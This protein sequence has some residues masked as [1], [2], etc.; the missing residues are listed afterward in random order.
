MEIDGAFERLRAEAD[1]NLAADAVDPARRRFELSLEVRYPG[2]DSTLR[3]EAEAGEGLE[4]V[5]GRFHA[6]HEH[7]FGHSSRDSDV[8]F[9]AAR[10]VGT[11]LGQT[12][13]M[14]AEM[15]ADPGEPIESRPILFD[16]AAGRIETPIYVRETLA[17]GQRIAGPAIVEQMDTTTIVPPEFDS[18]V[19]P[20]GSMIRYRK[21]GGGMSNDR[22]T[23]AVI[24]S[25][26]RATALEMSEALR[27]SAH[28]PIIREMF[29]YSC[30]VFTADGEI[31]AQDELIPAFLGAMAS[32]IKHVSIEAARYD[33]DDGDAFIANDPYRGG[34][35]TPDLQVFVPSS[36]TTG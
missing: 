35:H 29:D 30:A 20:T 24:G 33:L 5:A 11:G 12:P 9:V 34:T 13:E 19:D 16:P 26:L 32:T 14:Q 27:R 36:S 31:V 28:S 18:L 1:E 22:V 4:L 3:V 10:L 7:T 17:V 2:Q 23:V 15:P 25:A 8:E 21:R 6:L